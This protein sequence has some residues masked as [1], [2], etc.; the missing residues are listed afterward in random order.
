MSEEASRKRV[1]AAF[2]IGVGVAAIV[3]LGAGTAVAAVPSLLSPAGVS[4]ANGISAEPKP[5]PSYAKNSK[6]Q[7]FGSAAEAT[8][9]EAEPELILV[10]ATNGKEGYVLK[11][12]LDA[13]NGQTASE[14]FKSPEDALKWQETQGRKDQVIP[15]YKSDG[16]TR[17][18]TFLVFGA[19]SQEQEAA[20]VSE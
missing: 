5:D 8:S 13:A 3:G 7:T 2:L 19:D 17:I 14:S 9:P 16:I 15:V 11:S 6:G 12:D 20:E 1:S 18:G 10:V 4:P